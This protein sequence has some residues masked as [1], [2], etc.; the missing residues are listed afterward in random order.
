MPV[1]PEDFQQAAA[2]LFAQEDEIY[3][4]ASIS[5]SYYGV[6]HSMKRTEEQLSLTNHRKVTGS[7]DHAVLISKF[8]TLCDQP[9]L[10]DEIAKLLKRVGI[11]TN[12]L[13]LNRVRADYRLEASIIKDTVEH[14]LIQANKIHA[15]LHEAE[16]KFQHLDKPLS[17]R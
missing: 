5:R 4:R 9:Q 17:P 15:L 16:V 11:M 1:S 14:H 2:F 6:F 3:L 13:K 8:S 12:Q 7:G 10:T